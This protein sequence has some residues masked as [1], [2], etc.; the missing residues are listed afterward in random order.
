MISRKT[1]LTAA[2]LALIWGC[3]NHPASIHSL[4]D[5]LTV[6]DYGTSRRGAYLREGKGVVICAEP[7][8]DIAVSTNSDLSLSLRSVIESAGDISLKNKL[9]EQIFDLA[10]RSQ[11]LQMQRE[12]LYRLCELQANTG[13][14]AKDLVRLYA[15]VIKTSQII[16]IKEFANSDAPRDVKDA[17]LKELVTE[18]VLKPK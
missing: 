17:F 4:K 3:S 10:K 18:D 15:T 12:A 1:L 5:G 8:P 6:V 11:A 2:S 14:E 9:N 7:A 13:M 16:A